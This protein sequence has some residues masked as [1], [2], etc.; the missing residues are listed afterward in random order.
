MALFTTEVMTDV[1][2]RDETVLFLCL[3]RWYL[4]QYLI[5]NFSFHNFT[6]FDRTATGSR[7]SSAK[8]KVE[9]KESRVDTLYKI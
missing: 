2:F 4:V 1:K 6:V 5:L 8:V 3:A 9:E 7:L